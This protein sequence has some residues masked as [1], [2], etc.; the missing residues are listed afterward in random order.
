MKRATARE[1]KAL[2]RLAN[3]ATKAAEKRA[4]A[5]DGE[6]GSRKDRSRL[7]VRAVSVFDEVNDSKAGG[8]VTE[9]HG[10]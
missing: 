5:K 7:S 6:G 10:E 1:E 3:A 9:A 2:G 8:A 4:A